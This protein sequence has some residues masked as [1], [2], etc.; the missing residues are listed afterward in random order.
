MTDNITDIKIYP[1]YAILI[2]QGGAE[3]VIPRSFP[4]F[5]FKI[6]MYLQVLYY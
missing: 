4:N 2:L 3:V 1:N 5:Q 6:K